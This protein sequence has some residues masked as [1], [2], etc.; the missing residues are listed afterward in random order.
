MTPKASS[1]LDSNSEKIV[2]IKN[3]EIFSLHCF[4]YM[5]IQN[6]DKDYNLFQNSI[7][8]NGFH[9]LTFKTTDPATTTFSFSVSRTKHA[10][11]TYK[12]ILDM[13]FDNFGYLWINNKQ[14]L[15]YSE[16]LQVLTL[17]SASKDDIYKFHALDDAYNV[18]DNHLYVDITLFYK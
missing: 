14:I 3:M 5:G 9:D 18:I 13:D 16:A 10:K 7:G 1:E 2:A 11:Y 15:N 6:C 4:V 17:N 12:A 8:Y